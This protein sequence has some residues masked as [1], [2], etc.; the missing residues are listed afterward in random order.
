[1]DGIRNYIMGVVAVSMICSIVLTLSSKG[2]TTYKI[3]T[4]ICG[5]VMTMAIISPITNIKPISFGTDMLDIYDDG[6]QVALTASED[7]RK[8][9]RSIIQ[10]RIQAYI[11]NMATTYDCS[12]DV[13]V[14]LNED[15]TPDTVELVGDISPGSKVKL[16]KQI[17]N[18][19]GIPKERQKWK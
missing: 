11:L 13:L 19:I 16:Q 7:S 6:K 17:E 9:L 2:K 14:T 12:L 18:D 5:V 4:M 3:I 8:E 15:N 1:M 10:E